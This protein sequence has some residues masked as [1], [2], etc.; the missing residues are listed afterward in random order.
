MRFLVS[1][2]VLFHSI[3]TTHC[4]KAG[5]KRPSGLL[6]DL[7]WG[8]C[9]EW[10][11]ERNF[12]D[13][14]PGNRKRTASMCPGSLHGTWLLNYKKQAKNIRRNYAWLHATCRDKTP[15]LVQFC[16]KIYSYAS[17]SWPGW[18]SN[19]EVWTYPQPARAD[20]H[21]CWHRRS[22]SY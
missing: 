9:R 14:N 19:I 6:R 10:T 12:C 11:I 5:K 15:P 1:N 20:E 18:P 16:V 17:K 13:V 7:R 21:L 4:D 2:N 8:E 3:T 22:H